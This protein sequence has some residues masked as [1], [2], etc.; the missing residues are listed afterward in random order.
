MPHATAAKTRSASNA[1]WSGWVK[2]A[3]LTRLHRTC[4]RFSC[5]LPSGVE[6]DDD[7]H[8]AIHDGDR[9]DL[10][11]AQAHTK[12][13]IVC[14]DGG[15]ERAG[16]AEVDPEH[17]V[18]GERQKEHADAET[19]KCSEHRRRPWAYRFDAAWQRGGGLGIYRA[20]W[21]ILGRRLD[22]GPSTKRDDRYFDRVI[23]DDA[24]E[25]HAR[26]AKLGERQQVRIV[27]G[28]V[29]VLPELT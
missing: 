7:D 12:T 17:V 3:T 15:M 10:P 1:R 22:R 6:M 9:D 24:E 29:V 11:P 13:A 16:Q 4:Q 19:C 28:Q 5:E 26:K 14:A 27:R 8:R 23:D 18:V 2:R 20:R 21:L 25:Q